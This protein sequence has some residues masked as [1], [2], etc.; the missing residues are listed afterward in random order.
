MLA[1]PH[2][3]AGLDRDGTSLRCPANHVFDI[4]RQGYVSLLPGGTRVVGDT[5]AM[6]AARATFLDGGHYAPIADA[7]VAALAGV[8]GC[9]VDV[10]AGTGYYLARVLDASQER[11]GLALDVSKFACRRAARA[12]ARMGAATADAWQQLPVRTGAA[13]TLL[14]VFAPRNAAEMH[15]VLR[16]GGLLVV[17]VPNSD[18]LTELVG[19]L[20]LLAVDER[21]QQ[22]LSEQLADRFE[23]V[24]QRVCRFP[25][26]LTA[27]DAEAVVG[28]G[29]SAWHAD[30][31]RLRERIAAVPEP[32][33]ATA[34][35]TVAVYRRA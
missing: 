1:C 32:V 17:V 22:R 4:A 8:Q 19:A 30:P 7:V 18:H 6:V 13:S 29:P 27:A 34:S 2:C 3:G 9:V 26:S 35:V 14:N 23:P 21:K 11:T 28:M 5:A 24:S 31:G 12:H 10:G 33:T 16:P 20:D 25:L 15:R